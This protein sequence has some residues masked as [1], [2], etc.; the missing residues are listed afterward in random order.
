[1]K[2]WSR[3]GWTIEGPWAFSRTQPFADVALRIWCTSRIA[4]IALGDF[5]VGP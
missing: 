4:D 5:W 2:A 3:F 1:M